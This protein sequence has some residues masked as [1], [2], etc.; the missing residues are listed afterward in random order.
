MAEGNVKYLGMDD[1]RA[2]IARADCVVL[3]SYS[4]GTPRT[5]LEAA[6]M[7]RSITTTDAVGCRDVV[8]DGVNGYLCKARDAQDLAAQ[9]EKMILL[10]PNQRIEMRMRGRAK[11]EAEF[12][13]KSVIDK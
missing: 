8:N 6:A 7:G 11:M 4:E 13:E 10:P 12:D 2:E 3:P 5:L 1:V 9:I